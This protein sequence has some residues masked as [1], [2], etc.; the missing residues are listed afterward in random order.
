MPM[1]VAFAGRRID[2]PNAGDVR[3]PEANVAAV[4]ARLQRELTGYNTTTL[5]S[6]AAC[7]ADLIAL[8]LAGTLGIRRIV[9]LPW[10]SSHFRASSVVDRSADWGEMYDRI[11]REVDPRDIRVLGRRESGDGAYVA[12]NEAILDTALAEARQSETHEDAMAIVAWNGAARER[13]DVTA[14]FIESARSR[15]LTVVEISTL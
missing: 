6:S 3:F 15:G 1:I 9:V 12:T 14:R 4:R 5:V 2:A 13:V 8:D 10:E 7:G 11:L